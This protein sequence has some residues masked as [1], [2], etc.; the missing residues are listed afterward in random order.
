MGEFAHVVQFERTEA[1][2]L[3]EYNEIMNLMPPLH[4]TTMTATSAYS[5]ALLRAHFQVHFRGVGQQAVA[6]FRRTLY[7][8]R[9][10]T[11]QVVAKVIVNG[12][13]M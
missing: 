5:L 8:V 3:D 11:V 2:V 10:Y 12:Q 9:Y 7:Y 4:S 13:N 1:V 6:G